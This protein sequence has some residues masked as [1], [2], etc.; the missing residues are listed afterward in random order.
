M[1][2]LREGIARNQAFRIE[3]MRYSLSAAAFSFERVVLNTRHIEQT[4]QII[5]FKAVFALLADCWS[6]VDTIKRSREVL[7]HINGLKRKTEWVQEF[8]KNTH[9]T[10]H[11]RNIMQHIASFQNSRVQ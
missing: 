7:L 8:L 10:E 1:K 3:A 5:D 2:G 6:V 11:F 9:N 4:P